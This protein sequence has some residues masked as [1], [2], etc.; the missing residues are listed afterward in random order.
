MTRVDI[1][2]FISDCLK[3]GG[4][5]DI[6]LLNK[7]GAILAELRENESKWLFQRKESRTTE[8]ASEKH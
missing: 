3:K 5:L 2:E 7:A 4:L 8:L 6:E 1:E